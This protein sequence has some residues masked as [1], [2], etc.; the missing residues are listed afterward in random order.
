M[1]VGQTLL[2]AR[3]VNTSCTR[4]GLDWARICCEMIGRLHDDELHRDFWGGEGD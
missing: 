4:V 1:S 3:L 2:T